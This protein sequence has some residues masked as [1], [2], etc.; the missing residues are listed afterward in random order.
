MKK[1]LVLLLLVLSL[2]LCL[3]SS[4]VHAQTLSVSSE[5]AS[6][7]SKITLGTVIPEGVKEVDL[8]VALGDGATDV[9]YVWMLNGDICVIILQKAGE[10]EL[11]VLGIRDDTVLS[12][13]PIPFT[14]NKPEQG[15]EDGMFY[16]LL[17]PED[18]DYYDIT[19]YNVK[20]TVSPDGVVDITTVPGG[21]MIM[22]GGKTAV[23]EAPD[24]SLYAMD[25]A[26]YRMELL[27]QGVAPPMTYDWVG[28]SYETFLKYVPWP[29]EAGYDEVTY[30]VDEDT[31]YENITL[32]CRDF[33][34]YRP[35]DEYRFVYK[36]YGWE[37]GAGYGIYDLKTRTDHRI[38]GSGYLCSMAG[39]TLYG[40]ALKTDINTLQSSPLPESVQE[41]LE[42]ANEMGSCIDYDISPDGRLLALT[43]MKF[44]YSDAST[45]TVTDMNTGEILKAYDIYNPYA[46][47]WDV[48]FYNDTRFMLFF[49]P[50][51]HGSAYIYLFDMEE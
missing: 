10:G 35:L 43:G 41:K 15:F 48:S 4:P 21:F 18:T 46:S 44:W 50:K 36:V 11:I 27:I 12:R 37:W 17:T 32:L 1:R 13:T 45:V 6:A 23:R 7:D 49:Y 38:T 29:D 39:N 24:R 34:M 9:D 8:R 33:Y 2:F 19:F 22:P 5:K 40:S 42:E 30:P 28:A 47:E 20:A 14:M 16:L 25:L 51:E 3:F 26:T 31:Y